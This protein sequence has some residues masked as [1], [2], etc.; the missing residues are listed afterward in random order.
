MGGGGGR[1]GGSPRGRDGEAKMG[2]RPTTRISGGASRVGVGDGAPA[3]PESGGGAAE[4]QRD[5]GS[6]E[7]G[8][9]EGEAS[10]HGEERRP[11]MAFAAG[12]TGERGEMVTTAP[13]SSEVVA[14]DLL[15]LAEPKEVTAHREEV[16]NSGR[17]CQSRGGDLGFTV[18]W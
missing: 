2:R 6:K 18:G 16:G 12:L 13:G 1:R 4:G 9:E 7:E 8:L 10:R 5:L 17:R 14:E 11:S 15:A 3:T